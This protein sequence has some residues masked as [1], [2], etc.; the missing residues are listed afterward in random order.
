MI[1]I[2]PSSKPP[3]IMMIRPRASFRHI[4]CSIMVTRSSMESPF[5]QMNDGQIWT[6]ANRSFVIQSHHQ[7]HRFHDYLWSSSNEKGNTIKHLIKQ[8]QYQY[9]PQNLKMERITR[10]KTKEMAKKGV[11]KKLEEQEQ[12]QTHETNSRKRKAA[13]EEKK[14]QEPLA[15]QEE[16]EKPSEEHRKETST[17]KKR[18]EVE[19]S[20]SV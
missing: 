3:S 11:D 5:I 7:H 2:N 17:K 10:S 16:Q 15:S 20:V 19:V 12:T 9:H 14:P 6:T 8:H 13:A 1:R 18:L 4:L